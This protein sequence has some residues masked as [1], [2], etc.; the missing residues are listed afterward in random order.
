MLQHKIFDRRCIKEVDV[1][2]VAS[3]APLLGTDDDETT[4][5][6]KILKIG[7]HQFTRFENTQVLNHV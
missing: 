3:E 7:L 6:R 2:R 4:I 5:R 1:S